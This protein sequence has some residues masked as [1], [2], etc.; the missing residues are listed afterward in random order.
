MTSYK[1]LNWK[2]PLM[3]LL[4]VSFLTVTS[5]AMFKKNA[6]SL[7]TSPLTGTNWELQTIADF[8]MEENM[9]KT[10][11]LSFSDTA[12]RVSGK[13]GCNG[14][15]GDYTL[16]GNT[17]KFGKMMS[18]MM[19]CEHGSNTEKAYLNALSKVNAYKTDGD[20]LLLLSGENILLEFKA[21]AAN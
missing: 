8:Q 3:A 20:K 6:D 7:K 1:I 4:A 15:G 13:G 2:F 17:I 5:C 19:Y 14:F 12:M 21:V 18:T 9:M 16:K 11:S 10:A